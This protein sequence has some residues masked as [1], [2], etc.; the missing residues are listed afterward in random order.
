MRKTP[1]SV[2]TKLFT[3][4]TTFIDIIIVFPNMWSHILNSKT[5]I[6]KWVSKKFYVY[7]NINQGRKLNK[8]LILK[9]LT[10]QIYDW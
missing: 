3:I 9:I 8:E 6:F 10:L 7:K 1:G 4:E 5:E 2:R